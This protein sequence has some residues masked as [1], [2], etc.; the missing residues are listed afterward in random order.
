MDSYKGILYAILSSLAYA[1]MPIFAKVAYN[2]GSNST[3][4]LIFRFLIAGVVLFIYLKIKK[5]NIKIN[6]KQFFILL[7]M[8]ALGYTVT[9]EALFLSY[10]YLDVGLATTL[11]YIYPAVVC[12]LSFIF[13]KE[14]VGYKK[15][16]SLILSILGV[17]SLIAFEEKTLNTLGIILA[18]FSGLC[19]GIS[20]ITLSLKELKD[21]DHTVLIMYVCFGATLGL[22]IYGASTDSIILRFN[23]EIIYSYFGLSI[24]STIF[25]MI[26]LLKAIELI[27][28]TSAS[29]LGTFE[30][31]MSIFLGVIFLGEKLSFTLILGS[32]LIVISTIILAKD[33]NDNKNNS[34]M[35]NKFNITGKKHSST[36][37]I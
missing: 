30:A 23:F 18:L 25:S 34:T 7:I 11:H 15:I 35:I 8:G 21:L 16:I 2:N 12:L 27:G 13:F 19:Y 3:S 26:L 22:I 9:T 36:S 24:I 10:N 33:K 28:S 37:P 29:I 14:K 32:T 20:V 17:Y 31:I 6:L 5:V 1:I 4:A